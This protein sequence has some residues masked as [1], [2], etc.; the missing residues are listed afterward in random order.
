M[1]ILFDLVVGLE[2]CENH[3]EVHVVADGVVAHL[4]GQGAG[5]TTQNMISYNKN[6]NKIKICD[7]P[8][9]KTVKKP[10]PF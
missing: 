6:K 1:S 2:L 4:P 8:H 5:C 3:L 10:S 9:L 7:F